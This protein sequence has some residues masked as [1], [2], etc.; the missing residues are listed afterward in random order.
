MRFFTAVFGEGYRRPGLADVA[1][2][3]RELYAA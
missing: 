3:L 1:R 2:R